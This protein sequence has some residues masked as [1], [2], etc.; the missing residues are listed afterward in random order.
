VAHRVETR[1]GVAATEFAV[2]L[3]VLVLI[4]LG[5]IETCSM[6]FLKQSLSVAAYEGGHVAVAP[7]GTPALVRSTCASILA[8]RRVRGAT[9]DIV[10]G[11]LS[12]VAAGDYFE[13]RVSAPTG[14]NAI[15]PLSFFRGQTLRAS[16]TLMK[17]L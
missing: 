16:A 15:L 13:V 3:P 7:D 11:N 10:P 17:E 1:R 4:L 6:I 5:V 2:C 9:V 12:A 8:D 14:P